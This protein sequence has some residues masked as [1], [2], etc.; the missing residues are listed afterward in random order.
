MT[1]GALQIVFDLVFAGKSTIR[2]HGDD[3]KEESI[4]KELKETQKPFSAYRFR[5]YCTTQ[6][7]G[8]HCQVKGVCVI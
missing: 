1:N 4:R 3:I 8:S 2:D 6:G 5:R 7:T